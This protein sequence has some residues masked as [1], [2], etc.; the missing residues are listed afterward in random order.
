MNKGKYLRRRVPLKGLA[1]LSLTLCGWGAARPLGYISQD[2]Y[3]TYVL[4]PDGDFINRLKNE[5]G[6]LNVGLWQLTSA[7]YYMFQDARNVLSLKDLSSLASNQYSKKDIKSVAGIRII[8]AGIINSFD[9]QGNRVS[10][11]YFGFIMQITKNNYDKISTNFGGDLV[12]HFQYCTMQSNRIG[13]L[14]YNTMDSYLGVFN[15]NGGQGW[16]SRS[17]WEIVNKYFRTAADDS[18]P[19][20]YLN[21]K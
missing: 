15:D 6:S 18:I 8:D 17:R 14:D 3:L 20:A 13:Y 12:S 7:V 5:C 9:K 21:S 10:T 11:P 4:Q 2:N 1:L 19:K 16:F